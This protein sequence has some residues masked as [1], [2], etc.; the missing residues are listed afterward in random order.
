MGKE[1]WRDKGKQRKRR[2]QRV[3]VGRELCKKSSNDVIRMIIL[4]QGIRD[5]NAS[6]ID[7]IFY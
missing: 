3:K 6:Q 2:E 1:W 4:K 7:V 5:T